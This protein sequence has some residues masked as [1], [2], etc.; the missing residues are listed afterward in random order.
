MNIALVSGDDW[1]GLY[2]N[3]ELVM[4]NHSLRLVDVLQCLTDRCDDICDFKQITA[5]E[6]W[7]ESWGN[8][9]QRLDAVEE[10]KE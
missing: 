8:L 10:S 1:Q 7:L 5:D 6:E 4:Q 3:G 2:L 9:P